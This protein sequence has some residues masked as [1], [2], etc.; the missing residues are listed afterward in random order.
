[1]KQ[2]RLLARNHLTDILELEDSLVL[3]GESAEYLSVALARLE[4][5]ERTCRHY[6]TTEANR[7]RYLFRF[8]G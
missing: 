4:V 8:A 6:P 5:Q 2:V 7:G 3:V 1:M